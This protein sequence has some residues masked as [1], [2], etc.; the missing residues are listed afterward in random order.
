M[1]EDRPHDATDHSSGVY[2]NLGHGTGT[3]SLLAGAEVDGLPIGGA[4]FL[5]IVPLRVANSVILFRNSDIAKAFD[6]VHGLFPDTETRVH[7]I[8]MS[9]G[10]LPS[11]AWADAVNALYERGIF[12]VTAAGNNFGNLPTRMIV[13]PARF[14]RVVAACGVMADEKPYADLPRRLS[15]GDYGPASKMDT[16]IAAFIPKHALGSDRL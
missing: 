10:G 12:L 7:V 5:D 13:Y 8:T 15:R 1:D 3:L 16:A 6:Y 9:M 11:R 2:N 4:P 14:R